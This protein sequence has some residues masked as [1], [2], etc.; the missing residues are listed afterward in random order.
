MNLGDKESSPGI[1][2]CPERLTGNAARLESILILPEA[3]KPTEGS[4]GRKGS[5][6]LTLVVLEVSTH[7]YPFQ[8]VTKCV[9]VCACACVIA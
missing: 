7:P 1:F 2:T 3:I 5:E 4:V 9:C 6:N 8:K